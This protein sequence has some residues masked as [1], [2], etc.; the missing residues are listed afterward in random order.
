LYELLGHPD[1]AR[2]EWQRAAG[3]RARAERDKEDL[4]AA[5]RDP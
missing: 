5:P 2:Q 3:A 4:P 1:R